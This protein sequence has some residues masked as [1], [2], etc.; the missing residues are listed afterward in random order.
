[1]NTD[2]SQYLI[3]R[4]ASTV[5]RKMTAYQLYFAGLARYIELRSSGYRPRTLVLYIDCRPGDR[6]ITGTYIYMVRE[7]HFSSTV[8]GLH[9]VGG[10]K[11]Q[12]FLKRSNHWKRVLKM[13]FKGS[14]CF[15]FPEDVVT[16]TVKESLRLPKVVHYKLS[17][18]RS[19]KC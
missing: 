15:Q 17:L 7:T 4:Y 14:G 5:V 13:I 6:S 2:M 19:R 12:P 16:S 8:P 3:I 18:F 11:C 10:V 9:N 1:M